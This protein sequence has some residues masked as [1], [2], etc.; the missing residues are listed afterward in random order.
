MAK[1]TTN[2]KKRGMVSTDRAKKLGLADRADAD[3][4]D[5]TDEE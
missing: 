2:G 3:A 4:T 5:S 1:D